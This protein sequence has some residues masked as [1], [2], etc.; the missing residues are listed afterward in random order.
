M[1]K[2]QNHV[3]RWKARLQQVAME[4]LHKPDFKVKQIADAMCVSER[5]L[6]NQTIEYLGMS[7]RAYVHQLRLQQAVTILQNNH[8]VD[9]EQIARKV[10]FKDAR[11]LGKQLQHHLDN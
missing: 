7:P 9:L 8:K 1:I 10:G 5:T 2:Y 3:H 6:R 4:N 11:H